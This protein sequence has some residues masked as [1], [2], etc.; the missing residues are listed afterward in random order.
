[1]RIEMTCLV[2]HGGQVYHANDAMTVDDALG[3]YFCSCGWAK[4][5][6]GGPQPDSNGTPQHVELEV[7]SVRHVTAT[8][9][10]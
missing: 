9:V 4:R 5:V 6:D 7:Q 3:G 8:E 10:R 2:K 1:M